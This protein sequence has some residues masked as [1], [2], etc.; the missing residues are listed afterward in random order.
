[1]D[2]SSRQKVNKETV[3][4]NDAS[5]QVDLKYIY[6]FIHKTQNIHFLSAH[7]IFSSV[8]YILGYKISLNIFNKIEIISSNFSNHN[9]MN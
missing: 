9:G 2:R 3:A 1:M 8:H 6:N 5:R 4:L 7:G